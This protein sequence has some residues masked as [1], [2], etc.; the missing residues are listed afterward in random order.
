VL[1]TY[2]VHAQT[3]DPV[4]AMHPIPYNRQMDRGVGLPIGLALGIVAGMIG[5]PVWIIIPW[6]A[7]A[8]S[9]AYKVISFKI[10]SA[11]SFGFAASFVF[12][13]QGYSGEAS[14]ISRVPPFLLIAVVGG[15]CGSLCG[16]V[17]KK[18]AAQRSKHPRV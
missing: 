16:L 14:L 5:G 10:I 8:L 13:M 4:E 18:I 11:A 6:G 9:I 15:V 1:I 17:G 12:M 3:L 2:D 7:I